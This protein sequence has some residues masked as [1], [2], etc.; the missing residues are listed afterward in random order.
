MTPEQEHDYQKALR[1]IQE[2]KENKSVELDLSGL[3]HLTRFPPELA[4]LTSLQSLSLSEDFQ[5]SGDLSP[6]AALTSLQ[7]LDLTRCY[8]LSDLSPLAKLASLR[9]LNLSRCDGLSDLSP[10]AALTSL[11]SLNL[12]GCN[13]LSGN[14]SPLA[15]L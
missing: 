1:R 11:Q 15:G 5:F 4:G 14:L 10:L 8:G 7:S 6:L 3:A 2:A 13:Q 12:Q 9:E